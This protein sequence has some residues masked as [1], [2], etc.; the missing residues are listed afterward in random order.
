[1]S[2][3]SESF[4]RYAIDATEEGLSAVEAPITLHDIY[5]EVRI[6]LDDAYRLWLRFLKQGEVYH[7]EENRSDF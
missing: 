1:M 6:D 7:N 2:Y 5:A 4:D 3:D